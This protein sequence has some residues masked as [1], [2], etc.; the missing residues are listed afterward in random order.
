M[1]DHT[2]QNWAKM[3]CFFCAFAFHPAGNLLMAL[4]NWLNYLLNE[5]GFERSVDLRALPVA[6]A[7]LLQ[8]F[9]PQLGLCQTRTVEAPAPG[10]SRPR[11]RLSVYI[12]VLRLWLS[13]EVRASLPPS[14]TQR[15]SPPIE[16]MRFCRAPQH[17]SQHVL[18][19][20]AAEMYSQKSK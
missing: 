7:A 9:V 15:E 17:L 8:A 20:V 12:P 16:E 11:G 18:E 13:R 5:T 10:S 1:S 4:G 3:R 19:S 14:Q 2:S 6:E